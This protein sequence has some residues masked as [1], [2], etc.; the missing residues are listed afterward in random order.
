MNVT[1]SADVF[2][3]SDPENVELATEIQSLVERLIKEKQTIIM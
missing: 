3:H 2:S 1:F